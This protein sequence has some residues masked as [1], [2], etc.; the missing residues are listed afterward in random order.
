MNNLRHLFHKFIVIIILGFALLGAIVLGYFLDRSFV[1][2]TQ[3]IV[4]CANGAKFPIDTNLS[5]R[6]QDQSLLKSCFYLQELDNK[7]KDI[8]S[9]R[10]IVNIMLRIDDA[11]KD[12]VEQKSINPK[13][14]NQNNIAPL[15]PADHN[16]KNVALF[17]LHENFPQYEKQVLYYYLETFKNIDDDRLSQTFSAQE[18]V[19][20][21]TS[22][23]RK[24]S[25]SYD[26]YRKIKQPK[27]AIA[28]IYRDVI[29]TNSSTNILYKIEDI[30]GYLSPY[31]IS[32]KG[33]LIERKGILLPRQTIEQIYNRYGF[34]ETDFAFGN[35]DNNVVNSRTQGM[36][37]Y[38]E[39]LAYKNSRN[40]IPV[41]EKD[42]AELVER[43]RYIIDKNA[44]T[45]SGFVR[46]TVVIVSYIAY[47]GL[48]AI[49]LR[50]VT[51]N[52]KKPE[53]QTIEESSTPKKTN[54]KFYSP[55]NQLE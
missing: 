55:D 22:E 35:N 27:D 51:R 7:T 1:R 33:E 41:S 15:W 25:R 54:T 42:Y 12:Y 13:D 37:R 26:S 9:L 32:E 19:Y 47:V 23:Y 3:T 49:A 46:Y 53:I 28:Q 36:R 48:I 45:Y 39:M 20:D 14:P 34:G 44:S 16:P 21:K 18:S 40:I 2:P 4:S 8:V 31:D 24:S 52:S 29:N 11:A 6:D 17:W 50:Y 38:A 10:D 43:E 30:I 5:E